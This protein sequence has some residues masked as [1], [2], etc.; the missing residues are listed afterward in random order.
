MWRGT[1]GGRWLGLDCKSVMARIDIRGQ[2]IQDST[3]RYVPRD[4]LYAKRKMASSGNDDG[5]LK[6]A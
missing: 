2:H 4:S 3:M 1:G 6:N 5:V